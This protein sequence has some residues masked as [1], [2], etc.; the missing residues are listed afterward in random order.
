M[1]SCVYLLFH[2]RNPC[3]AL[4]SSK[5]LIPKLPTT[6]MHAAVNAD[7]IPQPGV[8]FFYTMNFFPFVI[9]TLEQI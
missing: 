8:T 9:W 2:K 7:F 6:R 4:L 3:F 5:D 1:G